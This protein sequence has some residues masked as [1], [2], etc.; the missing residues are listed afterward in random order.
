MLFY[1]LSQIE[2]YFDINQLDVNDVA[3]HPSFRSIN[4][5]P[6]G[7]GFD[8]WT[9]SPTGHWGRYNP[10]EKYLTISCPMHDSTYRT[11]LG[12]GFTPQQ[13]LFAKKK[14]HEPDDE[15]PVYTLK[16]G[17]RVYTVGF[18]RSEQFLGNGIGIDTAV[19]GWE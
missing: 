16:V 19:I 6:V 14:F 13:I 17:D 10:D 4:F 18:G 2:F 11:L 5:Y 3:S 7:G 12:L 1:E 9:S 15:D 8:F